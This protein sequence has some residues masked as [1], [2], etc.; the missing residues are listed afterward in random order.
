MLLQQIHKYSSERERKKLSL[1]ISKVESICSEINLQVPYFCFYFSH[2]HAYVSIIISFLLIPLSQKKKVDVA[3]RIAQLQSL[4]SKGK[5]VNLCSDWI[6]KEG[7]L[8]V[9]AS[10]R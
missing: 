1:A 4:I 2:S 9:S 3:L 10:E 6:I 5:S 7:F 8:K